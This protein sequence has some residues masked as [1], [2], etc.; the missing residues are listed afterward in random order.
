MSKHYLN[1]D[2]EI[3][4]FRS[5]ESTKVQPHKGLGEVTNNKHME[6]SMLSYV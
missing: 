4:L 5:S 3:T 1:D 2:Y 6:E